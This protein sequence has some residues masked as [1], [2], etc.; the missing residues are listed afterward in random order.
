[1]LV[2]LLQRNPDGYTSQCVA[3]QLWSFY[4][5]PSCPLAGWLFA[6]FVP[7]YVSHTAPH[8][9][10]PK[11]VEMISL[12]VLSTWMWIEKLTYPDIFSYLILFLVPN[13]SFSKCSVLA[14][15]FEDL[16]VTVEG[17]VGVGVT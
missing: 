15:N 13:I 4:D 11:E 6:G 1:M 12:P 9:A 16:I 10:W 17:R 3:V 14:C 7:S 2:S 5:F 8:S